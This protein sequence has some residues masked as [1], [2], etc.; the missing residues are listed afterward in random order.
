MTV[1]EFHAILGLFN[2]TTRIRPPPGPKIFWFGTL[3]SLWMTVSTSIYLLW[4]HFN[5]PYILIA[6]PVFIIL[7]SLIMVLLHRSR[8]IKVRIQKRYLEFDSS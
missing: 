6:L 2:Q 4:I 7:S 5:D 8:R 1:H 3:F